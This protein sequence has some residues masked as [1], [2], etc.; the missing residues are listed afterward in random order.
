ML[1][2]LISFQWEIFIGLEILS[3]VFLLTFFVSRYAFS[4]Q[5]LG[6]WLFSL[7]IS[8]ILLEGILAI[9][10][11]QKTGE[12]STF[13][14]VVLLFIVYA[15]TFGISD[16]K[17]LDL[18]IKRKVGKWRKVNL[19]TETDLKRIELSKDPK[20]QAKQYRHWWYGHTIVF[21]LAHFI[22]WIYYG[23]SEHGLMYY[24]T[25]LSWWGNV[26]YGNGPF[27]HEV[28]E[29]VSK[30]WMLVFAVDTIISWSYTFFPSKKSSS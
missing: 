29:Q 20:Y 10:V 6:K 8:C 24:L 28:I 4:A 2:F 19:L 16:F 21:I 15:C 5:R 9:F 22:F 3:L 11:Y 18:F 30:L 13:Q 27:Q 12:I 23:N 26:Q 7:F 25:D 17:K 1:D 14:I